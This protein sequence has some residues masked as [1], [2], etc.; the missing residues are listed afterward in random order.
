MKQMT[1]FTEK[2]KKIFKIFL[3]YSLII[4]GLIVSFIVG[5]YFNHILELNSKKLP[6][7]IKRNEVRIAL[8]ESSNIMIINKSTGKYTVLQDSLGQSIF[9]IYAKTIFQNNQVS[10]NVNP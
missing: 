2:L 5:Y 1:P 7:I 3:H 8:D 6:D 9:K 4:L 10:T